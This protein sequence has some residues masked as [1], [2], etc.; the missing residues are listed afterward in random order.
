MAKANAKT[1]AKAKPKPAKPKPAYDK[2]LV[3]SQLAKVR[4]L[5]HALPDVTEKISHSFPT[6]FV[7]KK[8]FA[9]FLDN[10]HGDGRLALW[11]MAAPGAQSMLVDANPDHYFVP[12]YVGVNGWVGVRLDKD[13]AWPEIAAVLES[14]YEERAAKKR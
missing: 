7:K 12:P 14:A 4:E 8:C 10:H 9:Y 2:K 13:A 6:F 11:L 1:K 5:C 3:A